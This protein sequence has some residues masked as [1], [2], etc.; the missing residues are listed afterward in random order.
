MNYFMKDIFRNNWIIFIFP[1]DE[2]ESTI[3]IQK[4]E[5]WGDFSFSL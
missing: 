3:E 1:E 2:S 4:E 5:N